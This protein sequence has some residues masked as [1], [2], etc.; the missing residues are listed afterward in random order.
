MTADLGTEKSREPAAEDILFLRMLV[1]SQEEGLRDLFRKAA[2]AVAVP[3]EYIGAADAASACSS[4]AKHVD[5]VYLDGGFADDDIARIA[6]TARA[7]AKSPFVVRLAA[8]ATTE[9]SGA[10][11]FAGRPAR[12]EQARWLLERSMRVRVTSHA[13]VVDDSSTMRSIVRKALTATR[14]PFAISEAGEPFAALELIRSGDIDVVF[15]DYNMP[16]LSGLEMLAKLKGEKSRVGVILISSTQDE[17][18][19]KR[20]HVEG[21]AFLKKPFFPAD[22]E[23]ALC[24]FYGLRALNPKRA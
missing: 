2:S 17:A 23:D 13:L 10:D 21:A 14:F 1:V 7:A 12:S 22:I 4:L 8:G 9:L 3:I 11:G 20:A 24:A 15:L 6:T 19:A 5:L 18:V 16:G